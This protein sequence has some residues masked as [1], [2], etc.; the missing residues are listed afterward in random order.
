M[1]FMCL[2]D[3]IKACYLFDNINC[4]IVKTLVSPF[5]Y[6]SCLCFL[7]PSWAGKKQNMMRK[8]Q[9]D[10]MLMLQTQDVIF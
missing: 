3:M 5:D 2:F 7:W 6:A 10:K 1:M 8:I 9:I 4:R